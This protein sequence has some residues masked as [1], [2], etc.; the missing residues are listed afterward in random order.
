MNE[1]CGEPHPEESGITCDKQT[2][3][4]TYHQNQRAKKTWLSRELPMKTSTDPMTLVRMAERIRRN[5]GR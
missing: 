2:P 5:D 4:Y 3:C 1:L